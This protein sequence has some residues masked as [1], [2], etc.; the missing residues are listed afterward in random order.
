MILRHRQLAASGPYFRTLGHYCILKLDTPDFPP[1]RPLPAGYAY[2]D[3]IDRAVEI[4]LLRGEFPGWRHPV[5]RDMPG[6]RPDSV[7]AVLHGTDPVAVCYVCEENQLGIRG[8][9][10]LHYAAVRADHRGRGLWRAMITELFR[11]AERWGVA[12][13]IFVTDRAGP[14]E[15]YR[16]LGASEIGIRRKSKSTPG[17]RRMASRTKRAVA[18]LLRR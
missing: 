11:H 10:E 18:G 15:M 17:W 9:G 5:E 13:V 12:G 16:R 2:T 7:V 8:Y 3:R 1:Q 14:I 6:T 4:E